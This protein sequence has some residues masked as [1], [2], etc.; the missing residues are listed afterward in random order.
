MRNL[1]SP[2]RRKERSMIHIASVILLCSYCNA[3]IERR[4]EKEARDALA[5]HQ[6]YVQCAKGY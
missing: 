4:T 3:E 1:F 5:E 2:T 6:R